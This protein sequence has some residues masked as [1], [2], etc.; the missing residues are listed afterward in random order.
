MKIIIPTFITPDSQYFIS[1]NMAEDSDGS[2]YV[3]EQEYQPG[4]AYTDG[5]RVLVAANHA[6]YEAIQNV[7]V[8]VAPP[9]LPTRS[10]DYWQWARS[11]D[12]W[13]VFDGVINSTR[14]PSN[15]HLL[16][17]KLQPGKI[18]SIALFGVDGKFVQILITDRISGKSWDS[19]PYYLT[20]NSGS[21][22][23][24][25]D[26]WEYFFG[27][28]E[29]TPDI[30]FL[31]IPNYSD[32][33]I[34]INIYASEPENTETDLIASVQEIVVGNFKELGT[35]QSQP[36]FSIID[37]SRK[38][39]DEYGNW[40]IIP[41]T[42]SKQVNIR[43]VIM[44]SSINK[45]SRILTDLRTTPVVWIPT[46][47]AQYKATLLVYGYY[48]DFKMVIPH[49]LWAEMNLQIEGLT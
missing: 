11:S 4:S 44:T 17:Y 23:K 21:K 6:V 42:F 48:R 47:L 10:N 7:P 46:E 28:T 9:T 20:G 27:E 29:Q 13:A 37:Y 43:L 39:I 22:L 33:V 40:N 41:K 26:W 8:G 1:C 2:V 36:E 34:T 38:E 49:H 32:P 24:V 16:Q 12:T 30:A 15:R 14:I 18:N 3:P 35:T 31:N 19:T 25:K 45:V 5:D